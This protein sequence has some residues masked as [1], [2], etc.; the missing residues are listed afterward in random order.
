MI[1]K[2][3]ILI[4]CFAIVFFTVIVFF[5]SLKCSFIPLDDNI[6]VTDNIKIMNLS[7]R[8]I[9]NIFTKIHYGL[10]HPIVSLSYAVEY[11][12]FRNDPKIYHITNLYLHVFNGL[13]VFLLFY[14]LSNNIHAGFITALFFSLHP[15]Q[16]E[17]VAWISARK[18]LLYA[19]FF[20]C[21]AVCYVLYDKLNKLNWYYY[22]L[23]FFVLSVISKPMAVTLPFLLIIIDCY[24]RKEKI[25]IYKYIPFLIVSFFFSLLTIFVH[26][27]TQKNAAFDSLFSET[28]KHIPGVFYNI[29][30][31]IEKAVCPIKLCIV[32]PNPL[33]S[34]ITF[35][36]NPL[37]IFFIYCIIIL[38]VVYSLKYTKKVLFGV[39][40]FLFSILPAINLVSLGSIAVVADRYFYIA[41]AGLFYIL[42]ENFLWMY[43]KIKTNFLGKAGIIIFMSLLT[44]VFCFLTRERIKIWQNNFLLFDDAVKNYPSTSLEVYNARCVEYMK[45]GLYDNA[46]ND[47]LKLIQLNKS[48]QKAYVNIA[49]SYT[50]KKDYDNALKYYQEAVNINPDESM[51]YFGMGNVYGNMKN[52]EK[53]LYYLNKA[54]SKNSQDILSLAK[55]IEIYL[56]NKNYDKALD[57][58][59]AI[60]SIDP[61]NPFIHIVIGNI[62][63]EKGDYQKAAVEYEFV[64]KIDKENADAYNMIGIISAKQLQY[65]YAVNY[66]KKAISIKP[67]IAEAYNNIGTIY[68]NLGDLETALAN[69]TSAV[70]INPDYAEVFFK[71]AVIYF[72]QKKY[73]KALTEAAKAKKKGYNVDTDLIK[74]FNNAAKYK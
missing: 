4:Y 45:N 73:R 44:G 74:K 35:F 2:T 58:C 59:K 60:I 40:F 29:M 6:M 23:L 39:L 69:F 3:L 22:S 49:T 26:Y 52:N 63:F 67:N 7:S 21:S 10:Y 38:I 9:Y 11:Y 1:N 57:D 31:Y 54:L 16:V 12:F 5:P 48:Y 55:R 56:S 47:F 15:M 34:K 37:I 65:N 27:P 17:P 33:S 64:I 36:H 43:K 24:N 18:D 53:S 19:F 13:L 50:N 8:N 32:Y 51:P 20:L 66:F 46:I 61:R 30:F 25:N 71:R 62:F 14:L 70:Q 72:N 28:I 42:A 68:A 41:S